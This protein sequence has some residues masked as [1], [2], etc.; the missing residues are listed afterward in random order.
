MCLSVSLYSKRL[1]SVHHFLPHSTH[2]STRLTVSLFSFPIFSLIIFTLSSSLSVSSPPPFSVSLSLS[3]CLCLHHIA[4]LYL[5][6][7]LLVLYPFLSFTQLY[8]SF[9]HSITSMPHRSNRIDFC[10]ISASNQLLQMSIT[11]AHR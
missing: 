4:F 3:L 11:P 6:F 10:N 7:Y 2:P 1:S 5:L 9:F 8:L